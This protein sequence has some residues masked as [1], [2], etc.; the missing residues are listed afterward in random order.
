MSNYYCETCRALEML[1]N[2]EPL[3]GLHVEQLRSEL[4]DREEEIEKLNERISELEKQ[5]EDADLRP[6]T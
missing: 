4:A 2:G 5:I 6:D 1:L 3:C